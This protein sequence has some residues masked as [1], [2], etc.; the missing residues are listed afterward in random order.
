[1]VFLILIGLGIFVRVFHLGDW[2]QFGADE[3]RD[4]EVIQSAWQSRTLLWL[5]PSSSIGHFSLGPFFY[6]LL[7]PASIL[8]NFHPTTGAWIV[9]T[10][11]IVTL[12]LVYIAGKQLWD[13]TAGVIAMALYAISGLVVAYTRWSW[14]PNLLPFF[15]VLFFIA[16]WLVVHGREQ[17]TRELALLMAAALFG[18]TIQLHA[19]ALFT[20]PIIVIGFLWWER[21][22]DIGWKWWA[23]A[24]AIILLLH[25]PLLAFELRH[26]FEN[27]QGLLMIFESQDSRGAWIPSGIATFQRLWVL[28]TEIVEFPKQWQILVS[29]LMLAG[30][31]GIGIFWRRHLFSPRQHT[32]ARLLVLWVGSFVVITLFRVGPI[33]PHFVAMMFPVPFVLL[34]IAGSILFRTRGTAILFLLCFGL[35][36]WS[37]VSYHI[38]RFHVLDRG[39]DRTQAFHEVTL[40]EQEG[41]VDVLA[42]VGQDKDLA[43]EIIK[44]PIYGRSLEYLYARKTGHALLQSGEENAGV[45]ICVPTESCLAAGKVTGRKILTRIGNTSIWIRQTDG[46]GPFRFPN[47]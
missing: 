2:L 17:R 26:G 24:V 7:L 23:G 16:L 15:V 19:S 9:V 42:V 36:A 22:K 1:M 3:A 25:A 40:E 8:S 5:G 43:V 41:L 10:A 46:S 6:D 37:N 39:G 38:D 12:P 47:Y 28:G 34:G 4:L 11:G 45:L 18:M 31:V 32:A 33:F 21:P 30:A 27:T 13:E 20:L 44:S 29:W 35:I 14:N